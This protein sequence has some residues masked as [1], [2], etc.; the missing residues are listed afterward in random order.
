MEKERKICS[1]DEIFP[2]INPTESPIIFVWSFSYFI[3]EHSFNARLLKCHFDFRHSLIQYFSICCSL[4]GRR[5][6]TLI[7][8]TLQHA[9]CW[10]CW[11]GAITC[12]ACRIKEYAFSSHSKSFDA[13]DCICMWSEMVWLNLGNGNSSYFWCL[14]ISCYF[15]NFDVYLMAMS[16]SPVKIKSCQI[17][18]RL[19][20]IFSMAAQK[21]N[22]FY[23]VLSLLV[24]HFDGKILSFK[25][26]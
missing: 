18:L 12:F 20:R 26:E 25:L 16:L 1:L 6:W 4:I 3:E 13:S 5:R 24:F 14:D 23:Q 17:Y 22:M 7:F 11:S 8:M 10:Y 21:S 9:S 15:Q 19:L 2:L